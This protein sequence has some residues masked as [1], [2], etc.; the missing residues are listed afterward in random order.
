MGPQL[1]YDS[2]PR[3]RPA[4][5][6]GQAPPYEPD[7]GYGP[8]YAGE[9]GYGPDAGYGPGQDRRYGAEG[10]GPRGGYE[11]APRPRDDGYG[12]Q[13]PPGYPAG[14]PRSQPGRR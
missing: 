5:G 3:N 12:G 2:G 1:V 8:P 14:R 4:P 10:Y 13:A 6:H 11:P 7:P 9:T